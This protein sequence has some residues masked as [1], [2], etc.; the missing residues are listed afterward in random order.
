MHYPKLVRR[1]DCKTPCTVVL[2][3][4]GITEDGEEQPVFRKALKCL[5]ESSVKRV[6]TSQQE[7]VTLTGEA[8]FWYDFCPELP[9]IPDGEITLFGVKRAIAG[10]C[11]ARNPDGTVNY[12]RLEVV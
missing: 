5:F 2:H 11:K 8:F 9:E 7:E 1:R 12:I 4:E 3:C 6:R 10:G